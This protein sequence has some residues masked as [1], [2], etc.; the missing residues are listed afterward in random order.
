LC[1]SQSGDNPEEDLA[2]FDNKLNMKIKYL[3]TVFYI[4][5]YPLP[6]MYKNLKKIL[7]FWLSAGY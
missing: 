2:K 4:S 5:G 1:Y 6:T 3:K 7:K